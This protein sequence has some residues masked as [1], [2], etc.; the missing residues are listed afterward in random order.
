MP[1]FTPKG[2]VFT[3]EEANQSRLVTKIRWVVE[4]YHGRMKNWRFFYN[5]QSN[6][7]CKREE[8]LVKIVS[9]TMNAYRPPLTTDKPQDHLTAKR[10][11]EK[12][13]EK[14]NHVFDRVKKGKLSS[15]G[16]KWETV[17]TDEEWFSRGEWF[18]LGHEDESLPL[19]PKYSLE[20][21]EALF[22][23][24]YQIKQARS[25]TNEHYNEKGAY[26]IQ[27]HKEAKDMLRVRMQSRHKNSTKYFLWLEYSSREITGWYCQCGTGSRTAGC[28]AHIAAVTWYLTLARHTGYKPQNH[29]WWNL[30]DSAGVML[31]LGEETEL[32][33]VEESE[34]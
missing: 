23:G 21:L 28:C 4:A 8:K 33:I 24:V 9:A 22:F 7:H 3:T 30:L 26:E 29:K 27:F 14:S 16:R 2:H 13:K 10:M 15:H 1:C 20:Q 34:S 5:R 11:L 19:L 17:P 31:E 6:Y 32:S 12:S 25:Y 18:P